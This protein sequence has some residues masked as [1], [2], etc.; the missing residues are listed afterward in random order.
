MALKKV[1]IQLNSGVEQGFVGS[2]IYKI[3]K[4]FLK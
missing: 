2:M 4:P 1:P 3:L